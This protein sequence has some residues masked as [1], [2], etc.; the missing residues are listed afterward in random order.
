MKAQEFLTKAGGHMQDRAS[1]YDKP[2]GER[3]MAAT[4]GA[5]NAI[6]GTSLTEEQGWMFMEL[7][8]IVRS[9]QGDYKADNYEDA[10]AYAAL[11]GECASRE[12]D[13]FFGIDMGEPGADQTVGLPNASED[14][15]NHLEKVR[16]DQTV[17][18]TVGERMRMPPIGSCPDCVVK[19]KPCNG[20][21]IPLSKPGADQTVNGTIGERAR[22]Q[23]KIWYCAGCNAELPLAF[24]G[25][26]KIHDCPV[27]GKVK[28]GK[29]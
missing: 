4:V 5:F 12:R 18:G 21:C 27:L 11:R 28:G 20:G 15:R 16:L 1:T 7:L 8:K 23:S 19:M 9:I 3:S 22:D 25:L 2:Q 24:N 14:M 10:V 26:P 17:I 29:L 6:N 13:T